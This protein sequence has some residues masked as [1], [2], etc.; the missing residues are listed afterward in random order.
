MQCHLFVWCQLQLAV[1]C[2]GLPAPQHLLLTAK[3]AGHC[4]HH[5][6]FGLA[7]DQSFLLCR[8]TVT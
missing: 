8:P 7:A 3:F 4:L 1:D 6:L 2:K 5:Q